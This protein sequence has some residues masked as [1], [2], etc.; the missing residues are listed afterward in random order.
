MNQESPN[1]ESPKTFDPK[2]YLSSV[3]SSPYLEVKWRIVWLRTEH[4]NAIVTTE[5]VRLENDVAVFRA[6]VEIPGG[7]SATA[8]GS[9]SFDD[10][11]DHIE[12]AE[13]KSL[14]RALAH[15]G[16]GTAF[17]GFGEGDVPRQTRR[18]SPN[19][20][21]DQNRRGPDRPPDRPPQTGPATGQQLKAIRDLSGFD[22]DAINQLWTERYGAGFNEA[23]F[24]DAAGVIAALQKG[25]NLVDLLR[26]PRKAQ[27]ESKGGPMAPNSPQE[28]NVPQ[29]APET[30]SEAWKALADRIAELDLG[31]NQRKHA[32]AILNA[33]SPEELSQ[34]LEEFHDWQS[35]GHKGTQVLIDLAN[36]RLEQMEGPDVEVDDIPF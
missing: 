27:D 24:H 7:G 9:E 20:R 23:T 12:K 29:T 16:Y 18:Q 6:Y 30:R 19:N 14:G 28:A 21:R 10:F 11:R 33:G 2:H 4:P 3:G 1:P 13:T 25:S 5:L 15:L 31:E 22:D 36:E 32:N 8:Y 34:M 17:E 26:G 35:R